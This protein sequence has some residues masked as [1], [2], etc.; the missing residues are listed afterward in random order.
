MEIDF[1]DFFHDLLE[2]IEEKI[3]KKILQRRFLEIL[4]F[5]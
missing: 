1:L 5:H 2:I 3:K 4:D